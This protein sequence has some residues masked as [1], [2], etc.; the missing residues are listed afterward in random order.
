[1]IFEEEK[2]W[3]LLMLFQ[4]VI[5]LDQTKFYLEMLI[6]SFYLGAEPQQM[7][8]VILKSLKTIFKKIFPGGDVIFIFKR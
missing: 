3:R 7:L 6:F 1:M 2:N 5:G 4:I 8:T